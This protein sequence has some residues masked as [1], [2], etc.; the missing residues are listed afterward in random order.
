MSS[1]AEVSAVPIPPAAGATVAAAVPLD[2]DA[3]APALRAQ[4]AELSAALSVAKS[5]PAA[6]GPVSDAGTATALTGPT[7]SG[8]AAAPPLPPPPPRLPLGASAPSAIN[9]AA[10]GSSLSCCVFN[11]FTCG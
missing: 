2:K 3:E 8:L 1:L 9:E 7:P 5:T 4:V 10:T 6:D 11:C